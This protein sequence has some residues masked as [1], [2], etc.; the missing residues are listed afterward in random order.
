MTISSRVAQPAGRFFE[1]VSSENLASHLSINGDAESEIAEQVHAAALVATPTGDPYGY[2]FINVDEG[3]ACPATFSGALAL[4]ISLARVA[5]TGDEPGDETSLN[6][7]VLIGEHN[8]YV[9]LAGRLRPSLP[10]APLWTNRV[11]TFDGSTP[12]RI[13]GPLEPHR[14]THRL[15]TQVTDP[16]A[17]RAQIERTLASL[18]AI[19]IRPAVCAPGDSIALRELAVL[20][21][22]SPH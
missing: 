7:V 15:Q 5:S 2:W 3:F 13:G 20:R 21:V 4:A 17:G 16:I 1:T 9:H 6:S 14:A 8:L 19:R 18:E 22:A 12:W 10:S 11:L